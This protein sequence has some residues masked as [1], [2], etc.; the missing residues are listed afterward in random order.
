[1]KE[2]S[3]HQTD[4]FL[5]LLFAEFVAADWLFALESEGPLLSLGGWSVFGTEREAISFLISRFDSK[6]DFNF[7]WI[8]SFCD[9]KL[10]KALS[11]SFNCAS[12]AST[13]ISIEI[14]YII[15]KI[16]KPK[17]IEYAHLNHQFQH[18]CMVSFL[19]F[20]TYFY[21]SNLKIIQIKIR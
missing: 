11:I 20:R 19:P 15:F 5:L 13:S 16:S 1:M 14:L 4:Y 12:S 3:I 7:E 18:G 2:Y 10:S 17:V 9:S 6:S 8:W 21:Y